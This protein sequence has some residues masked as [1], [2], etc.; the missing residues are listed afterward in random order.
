MPPSLKGRPRSGLI[1]ENLKKLPC[2]AV[3]LIG[4]EAGVYPILAIFMI[5]VRTLQIHVRF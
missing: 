4:P 1:T 5:P 2:P 3:P